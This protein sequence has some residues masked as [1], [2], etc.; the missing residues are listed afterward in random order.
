MYTYMHVWHYTLSPAFCPLTHYLF[1][2]CVCVCVCVAYLCR[3]FGSV[4]IQWANS[5]TTEWLW[6]VCCHSYYLWTTQVLCSTLAC[7]KEVIQSHLFTRAHNTLLLCV[8]YVLA[9]V[10]M[11]LYCHTWSM[12][13]HVHVASTVLLLCVCVCVILLLV[14]YIIY[15][16]TIACT[17]T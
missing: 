2:V 13:I 6:Y 9:N 16:C 4:A 11:L 3:P 10:T 14:C 15:T 17:C 12:Y 7:V 1:V 5:V 8:V